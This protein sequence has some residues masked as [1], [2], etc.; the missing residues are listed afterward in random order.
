MPDSRKKFQCPQCQATAK[1][2]VQH[3]GKRIRCPKCSA[4]FRAG[5]KLPKEEEI[6]AELD[7][8]VPSYAASAAT[9]ASTIPQNA[10]LDAPL[11]DFGLSTSS[12]YPPRSQPQQVLAP[13]ARPRPSSRVKHVKRTGGRQE[14]MSDMDNYFQST[15]IF[16]ISLPIIATV[17]PLIGLQL[18]RL[19]K[20]GDFAP[21]AA[22]FLGLIGVGMICYARRK[23]GDAPILGSAAGV[24]VLLS[25]IGGFFMVSALSSPQEQENS[26]HF[27]AEFDGDVDRAVAEVRADIE[28]H[29]QDAK[30]NWDKLKKE[31]EQARQMHNQMHDQMQQQADD[32]RRQAAEAHRNAMQNMPSP[33]DFS[34]PDFSG[35]PPGFSTGPPTNNFGRGNPRPGFGRSSGFG[36]R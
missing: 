35:A 27:A 34:P 1:V 18:R 17:L 23:Q 7:D 21:L 6:V 12:P 36:G 19:A 32:M 5:P 20:L 30:A 31:R 22:M 25:G 28:G 26:G 13:S 15:G 29:R 4:V 16:L 10:G 14:E 11:D 2:P 8:D 3:L 9:A 33:S 24:F